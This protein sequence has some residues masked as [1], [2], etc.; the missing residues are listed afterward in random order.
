[1]GN[2]VGSTKQLQQRDTNN[3]FEEDDT[4]LAL[5]TARAGSKGLPGKNIAQLNG[6]PLIAYSIRA[7]L[8]AKRIDRVVVSTD[9]ED[10]AAAARDAGA[11]TPF[12]RPAEMAA[13]TSPHIDSLVHALEMLAAEDPPYRPKWICLLQPTSPFNTA[14]DIITSNSVL[15]PDTD[16]WS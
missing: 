8:A 12:M 14:E 7:A 4:C 11:E 6:R 2:Q 10:I 15:Y 9:G 13:D 1:M 3:A 5:I 16:F